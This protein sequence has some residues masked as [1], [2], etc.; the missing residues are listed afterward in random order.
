MLEPPC[1]RCKRLRIPCVGYGE[2][3]LKF[4]DESQNYVVGR[5]RKKT[6]AIASSPS[7]SP[8]STNLSQNECY[9]Q[10]RVMIVS[11]PTNILT[12]LIA[13]FSHS[14]DANDQDTRHNLAWNFGGFLYDVP[15]CLGSNESLDTAADALVAGYIHFRKDRHSKADEVC[16]QKY[17]RA[18]RS[19]RK[20]LSTE[21]KACEPATLCAIMIIMAVEV[22]ISPI[23]QLCAQQTAR[24]CTC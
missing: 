5:G 4:Q 22:G 19:L 23:H 6:S 1:S 24:G 14:I 8:Q 15:Q 13:S 16:L 17:S 2:R 7:T 3:R 18:L 10:D 12:T 20:C 11:N 21:E 9:D